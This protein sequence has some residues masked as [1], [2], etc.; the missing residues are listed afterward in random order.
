[1]QSPHFWILTCQ[2]SGSSQFINTF[3]SGQRPF[4]S[5]LSD[6]QNGNRRLQHRLDGQPDSKY[7]NDRQASAHYATEK[8]KEVW[9]EQMQTLWEFSRRAVLQ[10]HWTRFSRHLIEKLGFGEYGKDVHCWDYSVTSSAELSLDSA[11]I[12]QTHQICCNT[13][14]TLRPLL[15]LVHYHPDIN[16][17]TS[18]KKLLVVRSQDLENGSCFFI[19]KIVMYIAF[20][21]PHK[22]WSHSIPERF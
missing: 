19:T 22:P 13:P 16:P 1:M 20:P 9:W 18:R 17:V 12:C 15:P 21:N 10:K 4:E 2:S 11:Y 5:N 14:P 7:Q 6:E 3:L 8:V